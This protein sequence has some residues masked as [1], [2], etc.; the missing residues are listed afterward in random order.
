MSMSGLSQT[1]WRLA[2]GGGE[3]WGEVGRRLREMVG[4]G[5]VERERLVPMEGRGGVFWELRGE[6][7][8]ARRRRLRGCMGP[9]LLMGVGVVRCMFGQR[10]AEDG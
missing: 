7:W 4:L 10:E 5:D 3:M 8:R 6:G 1:R 2:H 9:A